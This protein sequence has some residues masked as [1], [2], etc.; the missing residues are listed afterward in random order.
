MHSVIPAVGERVNPSSSYYCEC[1]E[2]LV[3]QEKSY[4]YLIPWYHIGRSSESRCDLTDVIPDTVVAFA[5]FVWHVCFEQLKKKSA[6]SAAFELCVA[7]EPKTRPKFEFQ[8][9]SKK[10]TAVSNS[11]ND[12]STGIND[13]SNNSSNYSSSS[14]STGKTVTLTGQE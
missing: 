14:S 10:K 8:D 1:L 9:P 6:V 12:N 7:M 13:S 3:R 2:R 5:L 4:S 11:S